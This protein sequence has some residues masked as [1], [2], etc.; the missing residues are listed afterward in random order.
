MGCFKASGKL[1]LGS[2]ARALSDANDFEHAAARVALS[3]RVSVAPPLAF[4]TGLDHACY[5]PPSRARRALQAKGYEGGF[6]FCRGYRAQTP[7][8]EKCQGGDLN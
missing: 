7:A 1:A 3:R 5:K 6:E 8:D 2:Y 4:L